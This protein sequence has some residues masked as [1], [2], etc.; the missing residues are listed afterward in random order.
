LV[1]SQF[2]YNYNLAVIFILF[3]IIIGILLVLF[4]K[5][6]KCQEE[7][8]KKIKTVYQRALGEY[9]FSGLILSGCPIAVGAAL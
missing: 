8:M 7:R 5:I 1:Y 9:T 6:I 3:P 2:I 4:S